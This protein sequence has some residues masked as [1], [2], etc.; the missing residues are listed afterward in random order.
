MGLGHSVA[1]RTVC[2]KIRLVF[3]CGWS[4]LQ[5]SW[6]SSTDFIASNDQAGDCFAEPSCSTMGSQPVSV[7]N[8]GT[9]SE[10]FAHCAVARLGRNARLLLDGHPTGRTCLKA[11]QNPMA[12]RGDLGMVRIACPAPPM[13]SRHP[14]ASHAD[15]KSRAFTP[16]GWSSH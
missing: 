9:R 16:T 15:V 7:S 12:H 5:A 3:S 13:H 1:F 10:S 2:L 11:E 6:L 14:H 4:G 8:C